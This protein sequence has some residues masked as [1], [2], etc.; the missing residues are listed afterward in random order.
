VVSD[1]SSGVPQIL[2]SSPVVTSIVPN[3]NSLTVNF[4]QSTV[5]N[6]SALFYYSLDGVHLLGSGVT[7]S[8]ITIPTVNV[9]TNFYVVASNNLGNVFS[10][11]STGIPILVGL[12]DIVGNSLNIGFKVPDFSSNWINQY[13]YNSSQILYL[14]G[15]VN[16]SSPTGYEYVS[17]YVKYNGNLVVESYTNDVSGSGFKSFEVSIEDRTNTIYPIDTL[18]I[19]NA[20]INND[21]T[22]TVGFYYYLSSIGVWS[23]SGS[24][25][26]DAI[27]TTYSDWNTIHIGRGRTSISGLNTVHSQLLI[28]NV[29]VFPIAGPWMNFYKLYLLSS[30]L[31]G[32]GIVSN[33]YYTFNYAGNSGNLP[34]RTYVNGNLSSGVMTFS[35]SKAVHLN[36][37]NGY[38]SG[39][40]FNYLTLVEYLVS[41]PNNNPAKIPCFGEDTR[42]LCFNPDT[43][44]EEYTSIKNIRRGTLV[45][46]LKNGYVKVDMIG[47]TTMNNNYTKN[48]RHKN[49]LY[50]CTKRNYPEMA[51]HD[52]LILTGCHCILVDEFKNNEE[53]EK[54]IEVNRK[55]YITDDKYRLPACVDERAKIYE[56]SGTFLIYHLALE[57]DDYYMNYG[58]YANGLLVETSSKRY[59]RELSNMVLL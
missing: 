28:Q 54:T 30:N 14:Q 44:E 46:T 9:P 5:G 1:P 24:L 57:N 38:T 36:P 32:T 20:N 34:V 15:L 22:M 10:S 49:R 35:D 53:R 59:M 2:G 4:T 3:K 39:Y 6:P 7:S 52:D 16:N 51:K 37:G 17:A 11:Q 45:K 26:T 41:S 8:P 21:G 23:F 31:N 43:Y 29:E 58:I 40:A 47:R 19:C 56:K 50:K 27:S 55:I 48:D 25:T 13:S 42:I 33:P 12:N 18:Y